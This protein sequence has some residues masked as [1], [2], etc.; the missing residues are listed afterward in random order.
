[1]PSITM[2]D[3]RTIQT[4]N[5]GYE[6]IGT[7]IETGTHFGQ[8]VFSMY[9]YFKKIHTI[10]IKKEIYESVLRTAYSQGFQNINFYL[11]DSA[12]ILPEILK[13]IDEPCIFFLDG[14]YSHGITGRGEKDTPLLEEI[15]AIEDFHNQ[16]S[17]IIIDDCGM[18]G[19]FDSEDDWSQI[20]EKN[21]LNTFSKNKVL[22]SYTVGI[23]FIIL[24]KKI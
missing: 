2:D 16:N 18:F 13:K 1:M 20:T 6:N 14:H 3:I 15:K 24:L 7:F 11:G 9:P 12:Y 23:R 22:T 21:I 4:N 5:P 17:I 8:T 19:K 10:E